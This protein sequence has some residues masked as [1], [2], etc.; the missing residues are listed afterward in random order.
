MDRRLTQ[1]EVL[2][3]IADFNEKF[4]V[5]ETILLLTDGDKIEVDVI[6]HEATLMC[7]SGTAWLKKHRSYI[8]DR[9]Y[10]MPKGLVLD[11]TLL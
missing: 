11:R 5:G 1:G 4:E 10:K 8:L 7:G 9:V 2:K 3:Q 6:T